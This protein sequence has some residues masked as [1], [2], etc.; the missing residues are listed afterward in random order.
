MAFNTHSF[1]IGVAQALSQSIQ[2]IGSFRTQRVAVKAEQSLGRQCYGFFGIL[3]SSLN[4]SSIATFNTALSS[5]I[6]VGIFPALTVVVANNGLLAVN[7]VTMFGM[8]FAGH[9]STRSHQSN[10]QGAQFKLFGHFIPSSKN[11]YAT[12][13]SIQ[14]SQITNIQA[15]A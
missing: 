3:G 9:C 5:F 12:A 1:N 13:K 8:C 6:Q 11:C 15:V 2:S 4:R 14:P 7:G 10:E